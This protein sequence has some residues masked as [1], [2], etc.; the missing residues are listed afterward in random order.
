MSMKT[1]WCKGHNMKTSENRNVTFGQ[2]F[3]AAL[4]LDLKRDE[5]TEGLELGAMAFRISGELLLPLDV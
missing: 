3:I 4:N 1:L 5:G 2:A